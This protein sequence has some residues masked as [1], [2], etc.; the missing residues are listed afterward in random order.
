MLTL[1]STARRIQR[2][3]ALLGPEPPAVADGSSWDWFAKECPSG[4][5]AGDCTIHPRARARI[6]PARGQGGARPCGPLR[7]GIPPVHLERLCGRCGEEPP[8][9]SEN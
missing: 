7:D 2:A 1:L 6:E 4:L 5:P 8:R 9:A 3:E